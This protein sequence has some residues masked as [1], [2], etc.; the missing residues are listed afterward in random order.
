MNPGDAIYP[1]ME[2]VVDQIWNQVYTHVRHQSLIPVRKQ[3]LHVKIQILNGLK[4]TE[5]FK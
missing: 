2:Q 5:G 4:G 1:I 3:V